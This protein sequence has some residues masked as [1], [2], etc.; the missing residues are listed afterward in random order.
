[1]RHTAAALSLLLLAATPA[2]AQ[3]GGPRLLR[4]P[5]DLSGVVVLLDAGHDGGN[6]AHP[7]ATAALVPA[8]RG[9]VKACDTVGTSTDAGYPEHAFTFDVVTRAAALLRARGARVVLTRSTDTGV[10]PCVDRRAA[11][12]NA[13]HADVA[14]SVHADG[15]PAAG[16]GFHVIEPAA[17]PVQASSHRLA[18]ALRAAVRR[19]TGTSYATY[20]AGGTGLDR[21]SDLAGLELSRVPKVFVELANMRNAA[22]ARLVT[23]PA[24]RERAAV[25]LV[26]AVRADVHR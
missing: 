11:I 18:L 22:D 9:R 2:A 7:G 23:S 21:R 25:A 5:H 26:D 16:R 4:A 14:I 6:A 19:N 12:G 8:G 1:M 15:G 17:G 13:A 24:W 20:L 3:P 10:G